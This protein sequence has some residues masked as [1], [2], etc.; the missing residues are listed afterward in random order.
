MFLQSLPDIIRCVLMFIRLTNLLLYHL[1]RS[2]QP[3]PDVAHTS[4]QI[5]VQFPLPDVGTRCHVLPLLRQC[6]PL[7]L[8]NDQ[9][10]PGLSLDT[11]T[12]IDITAQPQVLREG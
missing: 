2:V 11:E 12:L 10:L 1:L 9:Q 7:V 8:G 5:A 3:V 6:R 4:R